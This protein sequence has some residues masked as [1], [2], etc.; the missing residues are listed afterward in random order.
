ME[1]RRNK[2]YL[3]PVKGLAGEPHILVYLDIE[4]RTDKTYKD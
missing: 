1:E 2:F 3:H 4:K